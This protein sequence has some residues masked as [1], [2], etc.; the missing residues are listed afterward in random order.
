MLLA[1]IIA[2]YGDELL[3][4][5]RRDSSRTGTIS[6]NLHRAASSL[7]E[8]AAAHVDFYRVYL[9]LWF[10]PPESESA[11][12]AHPYHQSLYELMKTMFAESKHSAQYAF[13]FLGLLHTFVGVF[14][15]GTVTLDRKA[16]RRIVH[17]FL[18]GIM[19]DEPGMQPALVRAE[20]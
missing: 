16:A 13:S 3:D 10:A 20:E 8:F 14:L 2:V 11:T 12:I 1:E 15:S 18:H 9:S 19:A 7:F 5:V 17:Q 4:R 6:S